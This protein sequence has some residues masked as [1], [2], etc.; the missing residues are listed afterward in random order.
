MASLTEKAAAQCPNAMI[1]WGGYSQGAQV[2]HKAAKVL[3]SEYYKRIISVVV[4]GDPY[5]VCC[6][7]HRGIQYANGD[8][9]SRAKHFLEALAARSKPIVMTTTRSVMAFRSR[10]ADI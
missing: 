8:W 4:F 10:L 7:N 9:D 5:D 2:A 3:S 1:V 6:T